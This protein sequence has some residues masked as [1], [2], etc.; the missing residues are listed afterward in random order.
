MRTV[1]G[2][3]VSGGVDS[4]RA[5]LMLRE[6]GYEIV[7][8]Y[9]HLV[10]S[11][12]IQ[13]QQVVELGERFCFPVVEVDLRAVFERE[14]IRPFVHGYAQGVTPN[15]CVRCNPRV[16]FGVLFNEWRRIARQLVPTA[17]G[18]TLFA[19]G[20][21]VDVAPPR[22]N[23][24]GRRFGVRRHRDRMKDQSYFLYRLSQ[25]VLAHS[26]FPLVEVSKDEV[27]RWSVVQGVHEMVGRESQEICFIPSGSYVDFVERYL[28][29]RSFPAG[30][31]VDGDGRVIGRHRGIHRYTVGQRRGIGIASSSPYYVTCIDPTSHTVY[32]GRREEL[33][34]DWCVVSDLRWVSIEKPTRLFRAEVQ[35]RYR[36][37]PSPA[38]VELVDGDRALVRFEQPQRAITPGQSAVFYDGAW[39]LG[40]GIIAR[41]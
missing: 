6:Q 15:P 11:Q 33:E 37:V 17:K 27:L 32:V 10:D 40:G 19:T 21:Y 14:V 4:L 26:L 25:R 20:H 41:I 5:A 36:H 8:L 18:K 22:D 39:L 16:K 29:P 1:V 24:Y 9:M 2:V 13:W 31:I 3:A 28:S 38:L 12:L 23:P 7:G 35:V 30:P 34:R